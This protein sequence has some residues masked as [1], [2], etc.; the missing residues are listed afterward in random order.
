MVTSWRRLG[1][2]SKTL[3]NV[4]RQ[5]LGDRLQHSMALRWL[6]YPTRRLSRTLPYVE[7]A[8]SA[9]GG[10]ILALST[11]VTDV[12]FNTTT[13]TT[14]AHV[15]MAVCGCSSG[16]VSMIHGTVRRSTGTTPSI[17]L[18]VGSSRGSRSGR[19]SRVSMLLTGKIGTLTVGLISP[20][21]TNAIVR[22]THKRGIPIIFF[23]GRPSHGT[24]SDCSGTCCINASSGRSNVVRNSLVTG[25]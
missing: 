1:P 13:R 17:R 20:T 7:G 2:F 6:C 15:N 19:G 10:G 3:P 21:T 16:F 11:I 8:K 9:V 14:S 5:V 4:R 22:G 12:L 18:L 24:L 25:R 23:G